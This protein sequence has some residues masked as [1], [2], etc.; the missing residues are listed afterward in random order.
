MVSVLVFLFGWFSWAGYMYNNQIL[1]IRFE[2][3]I[4]EFQSITLAL[5]R[6]RI[7][8]KVKAVIIYLDTPGGPATSCIE[9]AQYVYELAQVKPVIAVMGPQCASGGYLIASFATYIYTHANT[10]TGGIGVLVVWVDLTEYYDKTGI[11]I[12]VWTTGEEKDFGAEWT[13]PTPEE[14][15]KIQSEVDTQSQWLLDT[16]QQNRNLS[17][18]TVEEISTGRVFLGSEAVNLGLADEIGD[19]INAEEKARSLAGIWKHI[20]VTPDMDDRQRFLKALL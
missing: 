20:I 13:S 16:I 3:S 9:I 18:K 2:G 10:V 11:K 5:H 8:P 6:A 15:A 17:S 12:W 19:I 7:D 14:Q 4:S 1:V